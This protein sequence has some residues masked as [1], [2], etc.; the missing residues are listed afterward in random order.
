MTLV[1]L[2]VAMAVGLLIVLVAISG[3]VAGQRGAATVDTASQLRDDA[4]FATDMIQ[5]LVMQA[6]FEDIPFASAPYKSSAAQYKHANPGSSGGNIDIKTL[7]PNVYGFNN[8]VP[9]ATDPL[10]SAA[11]R[12]KDTPGYGSDVLVLQ[13][14]TARSDPGL[15][16]SAPDG[17]MITCNGLATQDAQDTATSRGARLVSILHVAESEG[18][19]ALMCTARNKNGQ[20]ETVPLVKGVENFQVLYG[21][22]NVTAGTAP[23]GHVDSVPDSYLRADQLTV[24]GDLNATYTNWRRVRSLRIGLVLRGPAGSAQEKAEI[25]Y[26]P[27]GQA[28]Y[29]NNNDP[30]SEF[31]PHDNRLRQIATLSVQLRNCQ[32]QGYQP[33]SGDAPC[34]VVLPK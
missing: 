7:Q 31:T 6:G 32:N 8:A 29:E 19:L 5:R 9:N 4:R 2:L 14:Q 1:E 18:E 27:L 16:A 34:D 13:Y 15:D 17:S 12:K 22:D 26:H 20:F 28:S 10:H 23:A 33:S 21:V 24:T 30:G 11:A 3:L 25:K